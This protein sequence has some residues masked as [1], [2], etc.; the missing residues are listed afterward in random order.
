[1]NSRRR[2]SI[3]E[4]DALGYE[5]TAEHLRLAAGGDLAVVDGGGGGV[6]AL[7]KTLWS[8]DCTGFIDHHCGDMI[9]RL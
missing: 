2:T 7:K 3:D 9:Y 8:R 4:L 6:E 1:M 5:L